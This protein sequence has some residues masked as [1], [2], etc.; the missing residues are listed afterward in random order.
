VTIGNEAILA[1]LEATIDF[2]ELYARHLA[3]AIDIEPHWPDAADAP[4]ADGSG[5]VA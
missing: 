5:G 4:D 3:G 2:R 1:H